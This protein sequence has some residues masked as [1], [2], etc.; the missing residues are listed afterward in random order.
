[1]SYAGDNVQA[2]VFLVNIAER[3]I[4]V[5]AHLS[6]H[7]LSLPAASAISSI[8]ELAASYIPIIQGA[9]PFGPYRL[10]GKAV[11]GLVAYELA[12][13][14]LG[15]DE[16]VEF[17]G[18]VD[19]PKPRNLPLHE[20]AR[21]G[22]SAVTE[23][24]CPQPLP[25]PVYYFMSDSRPEIETTRAWRTLA[26]DSLR[27]IT[28][29]TGVLSD[30]V[31]ADAIEKAP[32]Q[33]FLQRA[34]DRDAYCPLVTLQVGLS[35]EAPMIFVPGAG[36]SLTSCLNLA[37]SLREQ[38]TVHGLQ[39]RGRNGISVP[40]RSVQAAAAMY[41]RSIRQVQPRGPYR[42]AGHSFGGW[43][44]YELA[45]HLAAEGEAVDPIVLIDTQPPTPVN[46]ERGHQGRLEALLKLIRLLEAR[47]ELSMNLTRDELAALD[48]ESQLS[49]LARGMKVLGD[50]PRNGDVN[51]IRG[52]VRVFEVN[53]NT[54][55]VPA[56][57]F[58]GCAVLLQPA[59]RSSGIESDEACHPAEMSEAW[60]A[61]VE[62]LECASMPGNHM[63]M[64]NRPHVEA[65]AGYLSRL[66]S[67]SARRGGTAV[68]YGNGVP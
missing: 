57:R 60:R 28:S 3:D 6:V 42:F 34:A 26:G 11:G 46:V 41:L 61:Y 30:D 68:N 63:T 2:S 7:L 54:S 20:L 55:Y 21:Q 58:P 45:C 27:V 48:Y 43:V 38:T 50:L 62:H 24:Y 10:L 40:H 15:R 35:C 17:L 25:I 18:I 14:L 49:R 9:Q 29:T 8:E 22:Q 12:S 23:R 47:A 1:M 32:R 37:H 51:D 39:P 5:G 56:T 33:Q 52:F 31:L 65:I 44:V 13:Q 19:C 53:L 64:L 4:R 36:G 16:R 59:D 66:W 67:E